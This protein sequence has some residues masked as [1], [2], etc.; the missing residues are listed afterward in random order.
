MEGGLLLMPI[1]VCYLVPGEAPCREVYN[2]ADVLDDNQSQSS[3]S[4]SWDDAFYTLVLEAYGSP[5]SWREFE[6]G[7]RVRV[8]PWPLCARCYTID[9]D[10]NYRLFGTAAEWQKVSLELGKDVCFFDHES[11]V[12][13]VF[14]VGQ[15]K[16][17]T[18]PLKVGFRYLR[19]YPEML[20][21]LAIDDNLC[22]VE[23]S[24]QGKNKDFADREQEVLIAIIKSRRG[25]HICFW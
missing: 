7:L 18:L 3:S 24:Y 17:F 12:A 6:Q 13:H 8:S 23:A 25:M 14:R 19:A 2:A 21:A 4:A 22:L 9:E 10:G 20:G 1:P 15:Q 5:K 16:S 11:M